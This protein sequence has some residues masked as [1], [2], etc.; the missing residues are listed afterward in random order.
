MAPACDA[1]LVLVQGGGERE[2]AR[3][4][5][6]TLA[7]GE[8]FALVYNFT[9]GEAGTLTFR[10]TLDPTDAITES[11]EDNNEATVTLRVVPAAA[12]T[13]SFAPG[14]G[15]LALAAVLVA[16]MGRQGRWDGYLPAR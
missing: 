6:P 4:S 12:T 15:Q 5:L 2:L 3:F 16:L 7:P 10:L 1:V 11:D 9:T 14:W 8:S 13:P